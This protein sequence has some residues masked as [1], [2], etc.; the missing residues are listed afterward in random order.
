MEL[1]HVLVYPNILEI[2][3]LAVDLSVL[4]ILIVHERKRA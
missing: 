4:R 1:A 2:L 3:I